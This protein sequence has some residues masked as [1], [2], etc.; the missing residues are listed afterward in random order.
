MYQ[1]QDAWLETTK[2][3]LNHVTHHLRHTAERPAATHEG[4]QTGVLP[5][6]AHTAGEAD[7]ERDGAHDDEGE[8]RVHG[9]VRQLA[10][11]VERVLL[12]PCPHPDGKDGETQKL[13]ETIV[14]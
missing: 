8:R 11:V 4:Q 14:L 2:S 7:D 13:P 9:D 10:E 12:R 3:R 5:Q 6:R 1:K